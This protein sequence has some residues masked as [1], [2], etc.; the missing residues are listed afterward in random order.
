MSADQRAFYAANHSS[1]AR[2]DSSLAARV[3]RSS[4]D[5]R[6]GFV[7]ARNG[8]VVP[9]L[10][11]GAITVPFQSLYDPSREAERLSESFGEDGCF[12]LF[13]L[14]SGHL[15]GKLLD[16]PSTY[17]VIVVERSPEVLRALMENLPL[18]QVLDDPRVFLIVD[19]PAIQPAILRAWHPV[20]MAGI[21]TSPLRPWCDAEPE[22]FRAAAA[23]VQ[24]GVEST[25]G[26]YGVQAHFGKRW[27][28]NI[29]ANLEQAQRAKASPLPLT[30]AR[31]TAAGPSLDTQLTRLRDAPDEGA[32]IATDTTLPMLV[33]FDI[34][35][36]AVISIDCQNHGFRHF[37][38]GLPPST[39]V[40]LDLA[41]PPVLARQSTNTVFIRSGHPFV[42]YL[43]AK[44]KGFPAVDTSGGNVTHAAIS[45]ANQWGAGRITLYGA[46]FSYPN[47]KSYARGTYLYDFFQLK[48]NR[49]SPVEAG[50]YAFLFRSP[51]I[52]RVKTPSGWRYESPLFTLYRDRLVVMMHA[53]D[54]AVIPILGPGLPIPQWN[55]PSMHAP[56]DR[57]SSAWKPSSS[58][59]DWKEFLSDYA[60]KLAKLSGFSSSPGRFF[61]QLND[62][63]RQL[64]TTL[65]PV[66]ARCSFE[67]GGPLPGPAALEAAREWAMSRSR[68]AVQRSSPPLPS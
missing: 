59:C 51:D 33:R 32:L 50:F 31:V 38:P 56:A 44:W 17:A 1:L 62:S 42:S 15:A 64:W 30:A 20:L 53:M 2:R 9:S 4:P 57:P 54:S 25:R 27:M 13:G 52:H 19:L 14:G 16:K 22:Y 34:V 47:G 5:S 24:A 65:L 41:S 6:I 3:E 8:M 11:N 10:R 21:R 45:L 7:A 23:M 18:R 67:P 66:A 60:E 26:D 36:E 49:L 68:R 63:D 12:V 55:P 35:P 46:D 28:A 39:M 61:A 29:L 40:V 58:L 48:E 37:L 43:D